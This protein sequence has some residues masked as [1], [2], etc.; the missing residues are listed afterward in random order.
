MSRFKLTVAG[1]SALAVAMAFG[2]WLAGADQPAFGTTASKPASGPVSMP[3]T[4]PAS[5]PASRPV[6][7][8]V[9]ELVADL[10]SADGNKRVAATAQVFA[11]GSSIVASLADAGAKQITPTCKLAEVRRLD[12]VYSLLD[13]LRQDA[14]EGY[15]T[16][17]FLLYVEKDCAIGEVSKIGE[18]CGFTIKAHNGV[19]DGYCAAFPEK[20][21]DFAGILKMILSG[22]PKVVSVQLMYFIAHPVP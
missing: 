3:A 1:A 20:G 17:A 10:A 7:T 6:S 16:D 22:E 21:K 18:R 5:G 13:G 8:K 9:K 14:V 4:Y 11:A 12:A 2:N 19:N 15:R